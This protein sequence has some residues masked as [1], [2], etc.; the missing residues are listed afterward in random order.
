MHQI[1]PWFHLTGM[2]LRVCHERNMHVKRKMR[3]Q[4]FVGAT[5]RWTVGYCILPVIKCNLRDCLFTPRG[6]AE[7]TRGTRECKI[8]DRKRRE[9]TRCIYTVGAQN[10]VGAHPKRCYNE[11]FRNILSIKIYTIITVHTS[12]RIITVA[13]S[14]V[15]AE[16]IVNTCFFLSKNYMYLHSEIPLWIRSK[17]IKHLLYTHRGYIDRSRSKRRV[18]VCDASR[19]E[20]SNGKMTSNLGRMTDATGWSI[21]PRVSSG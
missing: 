14:P 3:G 18:C 4:N 13:F 9:R 6:T 15:R 16:P 10:T 17:F 2:R 5:I 11:L 12:Q 19:N 7:Y 8:A 21:S 1:W 20:V